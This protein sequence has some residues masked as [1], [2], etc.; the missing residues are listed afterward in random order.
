MSARYFHHWKR[1]RQDEMQRRFVSI[2][3]RYLKTDWFSIRQSHL[4]TVPFVLRSNDHGRMIVSA[5]NQMAEAKGA[6][7]GM[8]LADARALVHGLEVYD[9]L[10]DLPTRLLKK[11]AE[12]CIRFS[13][14]VAVDPPDGLLIDATGCSHLWGGDLPYISSIIK[15]L[16]D[17]GYDVRAAMADTIGVAWGV[18]RFT[19]ERVIA[20]GGNTE[21]IMPL[22]PEALRL[23]E[24]TID[25]LH[26]LGLR[27]VRRFIHIPRSS[28]RRRFGQHFIKRLD[29]ALGREPEN[30]QP[31][32][33]P[34]PYLERLPCLEPVLTATAIEIALRQ[35]LQALCHRLQQEQ[36]GVR[37]AVFK[38]FR[39]DGKIESIEISTGR[40]SHSVD[41][42]FK[43]FEVRIPLIEPALGI[44]LFTLEAPKAEDHIPQQEN[45]WKGSE[46][47]DDIALSELID[48][49]TNRVGSDAI[50]RFLPAERYWPELSFKPASSLREK[51]LTGWRSDK[52]RPLRLL[53]IPE[54]IL[55]SAPIPDYP[56]MLFRYKGKV[57]QI[58]K[59]DGPER[60]EQEWWLRQGQHRDYYC[61]EDE[62]GCRYWL[63]RLGY[64]D[65]KI[66]QWFLH[67]F[68]P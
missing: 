65:E 39:V 36:K 54:R 4:R 11:L 20:S 42:L 13:P 28:L 63:F 61:V 60:I 16:N 34:E 64:Y 52:P 41:H 5:A 50:H 45:M 2:W 37:K 38:C 1:R 56:P 25:R 66:Q 53:P 6:L 18:A 22:P 19:K 57:H 14:M 3:F 9:D 31:V 43:L 46:G 15:K 44:E 30:L 23:E 8:V 67:G 10:P 47:L 29:M 12:W 24:A 40:P 32:F 51:P 17:R 27:Q 33:P 62:E 49:L 35:L 26:K 55:V 21:A 7:T 68:F 58:V 48:R 59:A